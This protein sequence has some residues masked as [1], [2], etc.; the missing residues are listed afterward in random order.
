[1]YTYPESMVDKETTDYKKME[2]GGTTNPLF[3]DQRSRSTDVTIPAGLSE[4]LASDIT[5][6]P[7]FVFKPG[8]KKGRCR[9]MECTIS[10]IV[11]V[12]STILLLVILSILAVLYLTGTR[13]D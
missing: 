9:E 5:E 1:M 4:R 13:L 8:V 3:D 7:K 6:S 11:F 2:E 12:F 10:K